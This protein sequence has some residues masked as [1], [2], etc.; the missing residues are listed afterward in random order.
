MAEADKDQICKTTILQLPELVFH[1]I[2]KY[3][4]YKT[5]Y[6]SLRD[7]C[8]KM[9]QHVD[10]H[11]DMKGIFM[12]TGENQSPSKIIFVYKK[13]WTGL[14]I[15]NITCGEAHRIKTKRGKRN[16]L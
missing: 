15:A 13:I 5:L 6:F 8:W 9:R 12:T 14:P 7:V 2:F 16:F 11:F 10:C 1:E 3:L 4:D